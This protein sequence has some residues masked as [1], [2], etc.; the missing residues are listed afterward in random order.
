LLSKKFLTRQPTE[1]LL[2]EKC[3]KRGCFTAGK[4]F[5]KNIYPVNFT[6]G[7]KIV[8]APLRK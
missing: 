1:V 5:W 8:T 3:Y 6:D 2:V 4:A 7:P